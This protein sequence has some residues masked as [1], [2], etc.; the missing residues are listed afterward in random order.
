MLEFSDIDPNL[1]GL[2]REHGERSEVRRCLLSLRHIAS[3]PC[4]LRRT[5]CHPPL[6]VGEGA[7]TRGCGLPKYTRKVV[8][9]L[10]MLMK[11]FTHIPQLTSK[12]H[13]PIW[14][15]GSPVPDRQ[16]ATPTCP[17]ISKYTR[18]LVQTQVSCVDGTSYFFVR[19]TP[20][21]LE[22]LH[23]LRLFCLFSHARPGTSA[24][25]DSASSRRVTRTPSLLP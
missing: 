23:L 18:N 17:F 10:Q 4:G 22:G 16:L 1:N 25:L 2:S 20:T 5:H 11:D 13:A 6:V 7:R 3:P 19:N 15:E 12:S 14:Y 9:G 24:C 8:S 21:G